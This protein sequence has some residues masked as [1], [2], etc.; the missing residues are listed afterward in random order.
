LQGTAAAAGSSDLGRDRRRHGVAR[1]VPQRTSVLLLVLLVAVTAPPV[2]VATWGFGRAVSTSET[3][4]LDLRLTEAV[5]A[6]VAAIEQRDART[7]AEALNFAR[8]PTL[9]RAL[10]RRD[11]VALERLTRAHPNLVLFVPHLRGAVGVGLPPEPRLTHRIALMSGEVTLGT[12]VAATPLIAPSPGR[13]GVTWLLTRDGRIVLG[14][15]R[16]ETFSPIVSRENVDVGGGRYRALAERVGA[17]SLVG[18]LSLAPVD[19]AVR[20]GHERVALAFVATVAALA[21]IVASFVR[22]RRANSRESR[23]TDAVALVEGVLGAVH[24]PDAMLE[25]V[26]E[27]T[28]VVS[29]AVGGRIEWRGERAAKG[30]ASQR[31]PSLELPLRDA[32]GARIG[33]LSLD[34]PEDGFDG[35]TT[36]LLADVVERGGVALESV[37]RNQTR[38]YEA[39]TD[40][41]TGL[42]NR[43]RFREELQAEI[44][45]S[46]RTD[47]PLSLVLVDLDGFKRINDE[48]GHQVGDLV[49]EGVARLVEKRV[50]AADL[51]ARLGG[52]EFAILL[53][54]TSLDGALSFAENVRNAFHESGGR[55]QLHGITASF[56]A[57]ERRR[58][59]SSDDLVRDADAALYTAKR[60]GRDRV[61]AAE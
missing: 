11:L 54:E 25:V 46:A 57:A 2:F 37:R 22:R 48:L 31:G 49:L 55:A 44:A 4:A 19:A 60:L 18:L 6:S 42:A 12:I 39:L 26:L 56:G 7:G 23:S 45:H 30:K 9:Q 21:L 27:A 38:E 14:P 8:S 52:D 1:V 17:F 34:P 10:R 24:D 3:S 16:G 35:S 59:A 43:R 61:A 40:E 15:H 28:M 41:L 53:R 13:D 50:R 29:G 32:A 33:R 5:G 36:R 58:H 51:A 20:R 47:S